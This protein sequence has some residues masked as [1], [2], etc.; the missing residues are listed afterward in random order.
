MSA[1]I[2]F[3]YFKNLTPKQENLFSSLGDI[4]RSWNQ[5]L[6]LIS[7]KDIDHL[8]SH[9]VL[10]SLSI[11]KIFEPK[12]GTKFL[13]VGTGGGFPGI[14]LAIMF[15]QA[16]FHLIDSIGKKIVAVQEIIA[17]LGLPN[18]KAEKIRAE[19]IRRE[20]DFILGRAIT[21]LGIFYSWTRN[22]VS[23]IS[24]NSISNGILYL[25]GFSNKSSDNK[26]HIITYRLS[27]FFKEDFFKEKE[28]VHLA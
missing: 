11:A 15:P 1:D 17:E 9:H 13:D 12:P 21:D 3:Q 10:H 16:H 14:P 27:D 28:I 8:Y 6:N 19:E 25:K 4:Y 2:I 23:P 7:R 18:A 22:K 5:K 20:Y 24:H 26:G